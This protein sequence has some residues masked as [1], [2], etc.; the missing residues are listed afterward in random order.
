MQAS[1]WQVLPKAVGKNTWGLER[2]YV[3]NI[4]IV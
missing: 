2:F 1:P 3:A 4:V